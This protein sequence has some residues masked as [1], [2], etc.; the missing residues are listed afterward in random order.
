MSFSVAVIG[1]PNVGKSTLFNRLTGTRH[2]IVDDQPGVTRDRREGE[3]RLADLRFRLF[4][5]AG[6]EDA[7]D[8]TLEGRMQRQTERALDEADVALFLI[9]ARA[10]V[11]P[12]DEHFAE[13]LRARDIPVIVIAN[14]CEGGAGQ[15]GQ[16]EAYA[17]A[18]GD[19]L[20]VSAE[21]GEG[22]SDLYDALAPFSP[23]PPDDDASPGTAEDDDE[24]GRPLQLAIVGRP[25][26]GKSTMVNRL[27]GD[28][29][30]L[31]GPE[32]GITRDAVSLSWEFEGRAIRL[33]DTAGLRRKA[34]V[35]ER[36]E[37]LSAGDTLR[38]IRYAEVVV[39]VLDADAVL[40]KQ[41][42]TIARQV[43]EEGRALVL[44][45][46]KWDIATDR[47]AALRR[48]DDRLATS[49][50]QARGIPVVTCSAKTGKGMDELMPAVIG[51]H[52]TWNRRVPTGEL[53]RWLD[54]MTQA[55]PPPVVGGRRIR[56]R[57]MTQAKTRPPT[58]VLFSGRAEKLP[59][60]YSRYLINGLREHFG[61]AG[62]PIRLFARK[63]KNPYAKR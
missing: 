18:L 22:L 4:D 7:S 6:L 63:G 54:V 19:P 59:E 5:T 40:D 52:A 34:R 60:S 3:G 62:V 28:D 43:I 9:D 11:T 17:L 10:G 42:L 2:A 13:W 37:G 32:A 35:K 61:L 23:Q 58:F 25:N 55:H 51:V 57:Y 26:V 31:T 50:P 12:M 8:E 46:N 20:P 47:K 38:A 24:P 44:A 30:M 56:L 27:V 15:A 21:H 39:L 14:K 29:R 53:N 36:L 33:V 45:V 49:L 1:R 41:D 16:L 48:L